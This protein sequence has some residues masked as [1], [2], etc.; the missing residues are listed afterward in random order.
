MTTLLDLTRAN[1]WHG[2]KVV[3][4]FEGYR[5]RPASAVNGLAMRAALS[6]EPPFSPYAVL[7]VSSTTTP[8]SIRR[9]YKLRMRLMHPDLYSEVSFDEHLRFTRW[10][11][12]LNRA[13]EQ[14]T[15]E[16]V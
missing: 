3:P 2:V 11:V 13:Y 5:G 12:A 15:Q 6:G 1:R 8:A 9:A 4:V 16:H 10:A 7:G 14:L